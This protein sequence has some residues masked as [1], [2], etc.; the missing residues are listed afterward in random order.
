M[1]LAIAA[2][3]YASQRLISLFTQFA[4]TQSTTSDTST[5][6]AAPAAQASDT[7]LTG[8]AQPQ[9]SGD[10]LSTLMQM[11]GASGATPTATSDPV[12]S[13]FNAMDTDGD[14]EVSQSEMESYLEKNGA[15]QSQADAV[16]GALNPNGN[17][18]GITE[19]QMASDAQSAA[20]TGPTGHH[21]H[22]H[23]HAQSADSAS[24]DSNP[25]DQL[26]AEIGS[27]GSIS[28][29]AFSSLVTSNGGSASDAASDFAALDTDKSGTLTSSDF[30]T[31]WQNVQSQQ[32][33]GSFMV[34]I[35]D[36]FAKANATAATGAT[37]NVTA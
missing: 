30:A 22:H 23:H 25:L 33:G 14:G 13:L 24:A 2:A 3:S 26:M 15:T 34:S 31:T 5:A 16:Y 20:A 8:S 29:D 18:S 12:Q 1:S 9:L 11:Q 37:T 27:N 35:L 17:A 7:C 28:Q 10:I 21:H 19:S 6:T 36:A 32:G 4:P